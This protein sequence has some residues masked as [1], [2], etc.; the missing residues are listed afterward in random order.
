MSN[1]PESATAG[2]AG[3]QGKMDA[4][5]ANGLCSVE[6]HRSAP[7]VGRSVMGLFG[8]CESVRW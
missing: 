7:S 8:C 5:S 1:E 6:G 3:K 4:T 2:K